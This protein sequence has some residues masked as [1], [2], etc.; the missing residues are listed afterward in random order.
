VKEVP[1]K[2]AWERV[3]VAVPAFL[4]V[5]DCVLVTPT[6]TFVKLMLEGATEI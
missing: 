4:I 1:A 6:E 3:S 2:D 5:S